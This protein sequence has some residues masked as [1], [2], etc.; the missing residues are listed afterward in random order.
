MERENLVVVFVVLYL[1][2]TRMLLLYVSFRK[3][4]GKRKKERKKE[5]KK[6]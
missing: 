1:V 2:E 3:E 6:D 4:N 5:R